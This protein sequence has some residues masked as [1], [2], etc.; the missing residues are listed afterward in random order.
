MGSQEL[1]LRLVDLIDIR[2][3]NNGATAFQDVW[4]PYFDEGG[5]KMISAPDVYMIGQMGSPQL[6]QSIRGDF[7]SG[8][9]VTSTR[10]EYRRDTLD[11]E[12][13]HDYQSTVFRPAPKTVLVPFYGIKT[14]DDVLRDEKSLAY[15]RAKFN[16]NDE[17]DK[18]RETLSALSGKP[19]SLISICILDYIIEV[20]NSRVIVAPAIFGFQ[21]DG[22]RIGGGGG[23]GGDFARS[24]GVDINQIYYRPEN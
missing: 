6:V 22:F 9:I 10:E 8:W 13:T 21:G 1:I 2:P 11:V 7:A 15:L 17:S 14:L 16:T 23:A 12:I 3:S 18:I 20:L 19:Q 4:I 24:R 5:A